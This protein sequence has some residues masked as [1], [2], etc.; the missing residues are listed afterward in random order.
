MCITAASELA[1]CIAD[2][3]I[4]PNKI[5]PT[6]DEW[7]VYPK[8]AAAV[9]VKAIKEKVADR[10]ISYD[11]LYDQAMSMIKRSRAITAN[12]MKKGFIKKAK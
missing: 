4:K 5:L 1:A 3:K 9:G 12:M 11:R 7:H 10:K 2:N 8:V 6:M